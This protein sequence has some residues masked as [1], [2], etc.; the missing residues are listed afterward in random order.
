M[1]NDEKKCPHCGATEHQH[2]IGRTK[3]GSRRYR[4]KT[5][6]RDYTPEPK[7]WKYSQEEKTQA[8]KMLTLGNTGRGIGKIMGMNKSN[9]YRWAR[10][11]EKKGLN[12]VDKSSDGNGSI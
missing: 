9:A 1:K 7:K 10:E 6:K 3:A 5:C 4:C 8:K 12:G 2:S 11:E